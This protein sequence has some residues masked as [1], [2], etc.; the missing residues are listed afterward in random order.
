M[1]GG[2]G[3]GRGWPGPQATP[4]PPPSPGGSLSNRLPTAGAAH[5]PDEGSIDGVNACGSTS[6]MS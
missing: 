5:L 6:W 2:G 3:V 4:P 1:W